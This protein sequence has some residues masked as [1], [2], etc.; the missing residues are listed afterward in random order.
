MSAA[1]E[2]NKMSLGLRKRLKNSQDQI[3][4]LS[5]EIVRVRTLL[6]EANEKLTAEMEQRIRI[7]GQITTLAQFIMDDVPGEP[8]E[9][10]GAVET[11]IRVVREQQQWETDLLTSIP[12]EL[13]DDTDNR[14]AIEKALHR[15]L[16][17]WL[18][19]PHRLD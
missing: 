17:H 11:I 14:D 5:R 9:N 2:Y 10:K 12:N 16:D 19:D 6:L 3:T 4:E 13:L 8:S 1:D 15:L 18:R 7:D